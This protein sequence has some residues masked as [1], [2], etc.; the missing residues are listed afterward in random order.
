MIE[1]SMRA[2]M[3]TLP[4]TW[5]CQELNPTRGN[6]ENLCTDSGSEYISDDTRQIISEAMLFKTRKIELEK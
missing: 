3:R 6:V 2:S 5:T 1:G 4:R